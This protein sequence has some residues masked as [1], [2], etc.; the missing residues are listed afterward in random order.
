M[1]NKTDTVGVIYLMLQY[2]GEEAFRTSSDFVAFFVESADTDL[3]VTGHGAVEVAH[4]EA[5]FMIGDDFTFVFH[6]L[7]IY[8][9]GK[10]TVF[11]VFKVATHDDNSL[12][13]VDLYGGKRDGYLVRT[14]VL[15]VEG[16]ATHVF[17]E[18]TRFVGDNVYTG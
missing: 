12:E 9:D 11:F 5:S 3:V 4:A 13:A 16:C 2:T 17:D 10:A 18:P 6:D 14:A 7:R 8:K 15:P 1:I